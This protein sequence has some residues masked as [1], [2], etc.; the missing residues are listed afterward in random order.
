MRSQWIREDSEAKDSE[1]AGDG[2]SE[3][4]CTVAYPTVEVILSASHPPSITQK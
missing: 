3:S 2:V 4:H 1:M